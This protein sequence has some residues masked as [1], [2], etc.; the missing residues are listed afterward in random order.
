ML[1][2][3]RSYIEKF[4]NDHGLVEDPIQSLCVECFQALMNTESGMSAVLEERDTL[5][6]MVLILD[7]TGIKTRTTI[8]F[9]ITMVA[10][11]SNEGIL[12]EF[13][14]ILKKRVFTCFG[15]NVSL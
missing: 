14:L 13:I 4:K 9:L 11:Y 2:N 8:L 3:K 6:S 7:N 1:K 5:R 12:I 10:H 15:F